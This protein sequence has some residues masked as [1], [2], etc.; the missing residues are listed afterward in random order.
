MSVLVKFVCI[1]ASQ[2]STRFNIFDILSNIISGDSEFINSLHILISLL[3]KAFLTLFLDNCCSIFSSV[4]V[5]SSS[6]L[7]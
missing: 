2:S 6:V 3:I 4:T 5:E 7:R 1:T